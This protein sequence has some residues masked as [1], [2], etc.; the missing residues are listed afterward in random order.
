MAKVREQPNVRLT[1]RTPLLGEFALRFLSWVD[2]ADLA[3][4][5][6]AY[7]HNGWRVLSKTKLSRMRL[8]DIRNE[9]VAVLQ[10]K[11]TA[12]GNNCR[13]TLRRMLS[14]ALEWGLLGSAPKIKLLKQVRRSLLIDG[15]REAQ[16][17]MV[18]SQP[19]ADV[20]VIMQDSGLRPDEVLRMRWEHIDWT[21]RTI[22][23]PYGKTD[24]SRRRL[25]MSD[26][27]LK[28]LN[29]RRGEEKSEGWV[30]RSPMKSSRL[31]HFSLSAIEHQFKNAWIKPD[32]PKRWCSIV[33][34]TPTLR[35]RWRELVTWPR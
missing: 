2:A 27:V 30:F 14:A 17:L 31:G 13:R 23:N 8:A 11:G 12:T 6:K 33:P 35:M 29:Q 9:H 25:P 34:G 15:S 24:R 28:T 21:Q 20:L 7:Y 16:L 26:R 3:P 1:G 10:V 4:K 19:L 5:T 22:F 32:Y 18:A